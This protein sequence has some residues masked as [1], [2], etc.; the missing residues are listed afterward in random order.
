MPEAID[1]QADGTPGGSPFNPRFQDRYR[2]EL[3]GLRQA[4]DVFL[5]GC[6]LPAAWA[7]QAQWCVLETGFGLGLNFL[8]TWHA[9][10]ADAG[11]PKV[12]HFV[13]TEAFP[14]GADDILRGTM[15]HPALLP[16]AKQLQAQF[17]GLLPG[18]HRLVFE[19]GRVLLTLLI[20]DAKAMLREQPPGAWQADSIYLD[21]FSP[22]RNPDIW[23]VHTFKAIA[24]CARR[25]ARVATWTVARS[26][27]D[28]L[29]QS[30]FIVEKAPGSPPK[31]DSLQG[32]FD[33]PWA[34][35][36]ADAIPRLEPTRCAVIG[37]GLAGAAAAAS[38]ARRG[39]QVTVLDGAAAPAAG[40]SSLPAGV[41]A[42]HVSPDDSVLSQLSRSGVRA[43]LQQ[44]EALLQ[45]DL[46]WRGA[47][48][49]ERCLSTPPRR[50]P[51]SWQAADAD[52]ARDWLGQPDADALAQAGLMPA[53]GPMLWHEKAGWITPAALVGAWLGQPG[54]VFRGNARVARLVHADGQWQL[55]DD[56][57]QLLATAERLV[58]AAGPETAAL[59]AM[60]SAA[61]ANL[62][63][64]AV[65][66]QLTTGFHAADDA[67]AA[68]WPPFPVNGHGSFVAGV[69]VPGT[70]QKKRWLA[71]ATYQRDDTRTSADPRDDDFNLER[72]RHLLPDAGPN[73]LVAGQSAAGTDAWTGVRCATPHRLPAL[74][75]LPTDSGAAPADSVWLSTAMGSRGLTF[76]ALCGELLAAL[77]HHEPLPLAPRLARALLPRFNTASSESD[78]KTS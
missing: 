41:L 61:G 72:L 34:L 76:A 6:G 9:W 58:L 44:A 13:S 54:I 60:H 4:E 8:V 63:L 39:W 78:R 68:A 70:G 66:G 23:D 55:L 30:G 64:Q 2:S 24:R 12:L 5:Y 65:R 26:V 46:H 73:R 7:F 29:A 32:R 57:G 10:Q 43:T 14:A 35:K 37:A 75:A 28:G 52:A 67:R 1:W 33:P 27:R 36:A 16:L 69:P 71:G 18:V 21:G 31:R 74:G 56:A 48:V 53:D 50:A 42:P 40:A 22:E 25:G 11:R 38:L 17:W 62:A 77:W 49:L 47:G 15:A 20:G 51:A 3:G 59:A 19:G 45:P